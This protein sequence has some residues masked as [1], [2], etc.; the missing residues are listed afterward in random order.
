MI[1][2]FAPALVLS[3]LAV[4][5]MAQDWH[6]RAT[7]LSPETE[8]A[9][10]ICHIS[11]GDTPPLVAFTFERGTSRFGVR[12]REFLARSGVHQ[13]S[14]ALPSGATLTVSLGSDASS[15]VAVLTA[16]RERMLRFL[17]H[18]L[19]AGDFSLTGE[20]VRIDIPA[21]PSAAGEMASLQNCLR[22]L[23]QGT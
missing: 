15:D 20:G 13:Y 18:F 5:A 1:R 8:T 2:H 4:P 9:S 21:L 23:D 7:P 19:V 22:L 6:A 3:A 10:P 12:A 16:D 14:G 11:S 17:E